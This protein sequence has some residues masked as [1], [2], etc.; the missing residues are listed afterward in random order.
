[1]QRWLVVPR[2][3][4]P[5]AGLRSSRCNMAN[6]SA[7]CIGGI[8]TVVL[9]V[10]V[11]FVAYFFWPASEDNDDNDNN[12]NVNGNNNKIVTSEVKTTEVSM[13]HNPRTRI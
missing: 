13:L 7:R 6:P 8:V 11:I 10:V 4:S 1:M 2:V 12:D 3:Q 9:V 5:G